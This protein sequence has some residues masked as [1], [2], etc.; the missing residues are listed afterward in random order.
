[1]HEL[2]IAQALV[3]RADALCREQKAR[4]VTA[5]TLCVG[6]LSGADPESLKMVF[7]LAAE[8]SVAAGAELRIELIEAEV[9]CRGCGSRSKPE[10]PFIYCA[11]C[12]SRE[13]ELKRG[14]ELYIQSMEVEGP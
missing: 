11:S 12:G 6:T 3:E 13:V 8:E 4:R 9:G 2:S 7:S 1:V 10:A 5:L 14:R